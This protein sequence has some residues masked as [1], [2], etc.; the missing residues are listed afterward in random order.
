M[1]AEKTA[2]SF[3]AL[4]E[5]ISTDLTKALPTDGDTKEDDAKI[6]AAAADGEGEE[7]KEDGEAAPMAKSFK[8]TLQNGE[9]ID[10]VDG[11]ELVKSLVARIESNE[12]GILKVLGET[13][14]IA[15]AQGELIKSLQTRL[16]TLEGQGKGRKAVLTIAEK[17][18]AAAE[19]LR[20]SQETHGLDG[21]AFMA[22]ALSA[23]V[24]G[25]INGTQVAIA[26]AH[27]NA[28]KQPPADIVRAV[29]PD[30]Q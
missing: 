6:E 11:A 25:R 28:G 3:D 29:L 1:S 12:T 26:E 10:A 4:L 24:A 20:K 30:A 13:A 2:G 14:K 21:D 23:Q 16:G 15:I 17:P 27:I 19:E 7:D 9:E 5:E 18:A 8:I 22:K